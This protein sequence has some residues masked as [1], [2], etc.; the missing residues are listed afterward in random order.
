VIK[1]ITEYAADEGNSETVTTLRLHVGGGS[2]RLGVATGIHWHMNVGNQIEYVATDDTFETIPWVRLRDSAGAV[3]EYRKPGVTDQQI[4]AGRR[5]RM[6]CMDCHNR[7]SHPIAASASRAVDASLAIGELPK[8]LP[9]IKRETVKALETPYESESAAAA[10]IARALD[11]FYRANYPEIHQ[12]RRRDVDRAQQGALS[13]FQRNVFPE[14]R[15]TFGTYRNNIGHVD[16]PGCFR[17]HD[18]EH[19][20]DDGRKIGQ[21]CET[22]HTIE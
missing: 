1:R 16:S 18:D 10:G 19:V 14:M 6:D 3:R 22:C 20:A 7:P 15:V 21:D 11:E 13:I 9:Y 5:R 8:S 17:C 2:E 4:A 12:T